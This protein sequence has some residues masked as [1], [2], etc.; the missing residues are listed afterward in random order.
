MITGSAASFI[1]DSFGRS[2]SGSPG[3]VR[4]C[5][6]CSSRP[7]RR[8][9][10]FSCRKRFHACVCRHRCLRC[11]RQPQRSDR[12]A[13]ASRVD[14]ATLIFVALLVFVDCIEGAAG[15]AAPAPIRP[16]NARDAA[17]PS[18]QAA[19]C[20]RVISTAAGSNTRV[21]S[22]GTSERISGGS[23]DEDSEL[24]L[25][26]HEG[27]PWSAFGSLPQGRWRRRQL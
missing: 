24:K 18:R 4:R 25:H 19:S 23:T 7:T 13:R 3:A 21:R 8:C 12:D 5:G 26:R 15:D 16:G 2:S 9:R 20:T 22:S 11:S 14:S 17:P 1:N 6:C 27:N 10:F